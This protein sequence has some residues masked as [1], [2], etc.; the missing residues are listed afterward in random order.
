MPRERPHRVGDQAIVLG[1]VAGVERLHRA[2]H[3]E[4]RDRHRD[5]R[6]RARAPRS[7]A[8]IDGIVGAKV[9]TSAM[10]RPASS[11][12]SSIASLGFRTGM[13]LAA[14]AL[15]IAAPNAEHV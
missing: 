10:R 9:A 12:A 7:S 11:A 14:R 1:A 6:G 8:V 2:G 15:S 4:R 3:E 5:R 13:R